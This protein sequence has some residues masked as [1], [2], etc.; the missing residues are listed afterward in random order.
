MTDPRNAA[1][2]IAARRFALSL[3]GGAVLALALSAAA[4]HAAPSP[5]GVGLPEQSLSSGGI[6]SG[7]FAWV[8]AQQTAFYGALTSSLKQMK[9]D[10][11]AGWWLMG[12]SFL[13]GV[14]HAAGPGHGKAVISSYVLA[15]GE[16]LRR[17]IVIS[18][19]SALAQAVTAVMVIG[20]ASIVLRMTSIAIT[21]TTRWLEIG[22]YAAVAGLGLYLV[23]RKIVRP[24]L[25]P[26]K[27]VALGAQA[28]VAC[29]H[30]DHH[31][32][33][34]HE[35]AHGHA[36]EVRHAHAHTHTH[37]HG[38]DHG[39]GHGHGHDHDH[40]AGEVCASC[41]HLHAPPPQMLAGDFSLSR[42]WTVILAVGLRPCTGALVVLVFAISQG[43]AWAGV[44]ATFA[45]AIGTGLT[46]SALATIAVLAKD[47][48]MRTVG[49]R[50]AARLHA[51]IEGFGAL[52]VLALGSTLLIAALG[53][54][55]AV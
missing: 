4:A 45:M 11:S 37:D 6:L 42:A 53:W 7:F 27:V 52:V 1:P 18:F 51:A 12:L 35:R 26:R 36:H 54:G 31:S 9:A 14:F 13:Y 15:N 20:L 40:A 34:T 44:A 28:V 17:G 19:A 47:A 23:W 55:G 2:G 30:H 10:G 43:L 48:A 3:A 33:H 29:D 46:V 22:S 24:L 38:H 49:G 41:G 21:E 8:S 32:H 16:T 50:G 5:F 39:H 25:T